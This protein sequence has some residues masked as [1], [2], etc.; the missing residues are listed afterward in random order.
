[1]HVHLNWNPVD[2]S[3]SITPK[4]LMTIT[5]AF[6]RRDYIGAMDFLQDCIG[7]LQQEYDDALSAWRNSM[8]QQL[9][10]L[11]NP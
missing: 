1:M 9:R 8:S 3:T 7:I 2:G 6:E 10:P 4:S 11:N 5:D